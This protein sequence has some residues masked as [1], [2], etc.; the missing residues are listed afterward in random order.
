MIYFH[1]CC[2]NSLQERLS[3]LFRSHCISFHHLPWSDKCPDNVFSYEPADSSM[4]WNSSHKA[5][6]S[7][8]SLP[9]ELSR[10]VSGVPTEWNSC[11]SR[12]TCTVSLRCESSG[13]ASRC[14]L[15][16]RRSRTRST[17][18]VS[19]RCVFSDAFSNSLAEKNSFHKENTSKASNLHGLSCVSS[20]V[21]AK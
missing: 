8:A 20:G 9:Y 7:T 19:R 18:E 21:M 15:N 11:R 2:N 4:C 13:V 3:D 17:C 1:P 5:S 14:R 10:V 6:S 16:G 12:S